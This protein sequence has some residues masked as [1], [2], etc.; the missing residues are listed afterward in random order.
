LVFHVC[1]FVHSVR[2]YVV[3]YC[4]VSVLCFVFSRIIAYY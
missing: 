2:L 1:T 3:F 4:I